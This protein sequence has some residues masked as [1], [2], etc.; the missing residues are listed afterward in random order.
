MWIPGSPES[1]A[2]SNS[3]E[4]RP[5][6]RQHIAVC[7][8][9][10]LA[11]IDLQQPTTN[12]FCSSSSLGR[13]TSLPC[14]SGSSYNGPSLNCG[15]NGDTRASTANVKHG[16]DGQDVEDFQDNI[17]APCV[18]S[19]KKDSEKLLLQC[20]PKDLFLPLSPMFVPSNRDSVD[21]QQPSS[22]YSL[23]SSELQCHDHFHL[24]R[25]ASQGSSKEKSIRK[26]L[27]NLATL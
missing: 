10:T 26:W 13:R 11:F 27:H 7:Q 19:L 23:D 22:P 20:T 14:S 25:R 2:L 17:T 5:L 12:G 6:L 18:D 24:Q 9:E 21:S 3:Q 8:Q 4:N 1:Q 15:Q 16:Q